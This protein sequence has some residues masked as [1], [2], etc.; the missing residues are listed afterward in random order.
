MSQSQ[1]AKLDAAAKRLE[2]MLAQGQDDKFKAYIQK[3]LKE[4]KVEL[5]RQLLLRMKHPTAK[6]FLDAIN[7]KYPPPQK[8]QVSRNY[9]ML[10]A[11]AV[12][13]IVLV[14]LGALLVPRLLGDNLSQEITCG[15]GDYGVSVRYPEDMFAQCDAFEDVEQPGIELSNNADGLN[16]EQ[17]YDGEIP[18]A[19]SWLAYV[20]WDLRSNYPEAPTLAQ[21]V[22]QGDYALEDTYERIEQ[23]SIGGFDAALVQ[24]VDGFI[25]L[26]DRGEIVSYLDFYGTDEDFEVLLPVF[27]QMALSV[28]AI[29]PTNEQNLTSDVEPNSEVSANINVSLQVRCTVGIGRV[30]DFSFLIPENWASTCVPTDLDTTSVMAVF[31]EN[32]D[33]L[34][35]VFTSQTPSGR[36]VGSIAVENF[37]ENE[38]PCDAWLETLFAGDEAAFTLIGEQNPSECYSATLALRVGAMERI[39]EGIQA[40]LEGRDQP[41]ATIS[42]LYSIVMRV[43]LVDRYIAVIQL[44]PP[45][46]PTANLQEL[47][48]LIPLLDAISESIQITVADASDINPVQETATAEMQ[49]TVSVI[50]TE[51]ALVEAYIIATATAQ[52]QLIT[53]FDY[54]QYTGPIPEGQDFL[55]IPSRR[56][57]DGAFILGNPDARVTV[58]AFMDF[59]CSHCRDYQTTIKDFLSEFVVTGQA[60]Y[61]FRM[62]AISQHSQDLF[63]VAECAGISSTHLFWPAHD[64][65][66]AQAI[67][68]QININTYVLDSANALGLNYDELLDCTTSA[69]QYVVDAQVA[70]ELGVTGIPTLGWRLDGGYLRLDGLSQQPTL[71]E[72]RSLIANYE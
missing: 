62:L 42:P 67:L 34:D 58:V 33:A 41:T 68:G 13:A 64:Y 20:A 23:L 54:S 49:G 57:K 4:D 44:A 8:R 9:A 29:T 72:L 59:L 40:E 46:G 18:P 36:V 35:Q 55:G 37:E 43:M 26:I 38:L 48:D 30:R 69:D 17:G 2:T 28:E 63:A 12:A 15:Q 25:L 22:T 45:G 32:Q 61:E 5:A 24:Y 52:A 71:D 3:L 21:S 16:W 31:A 19:G 10:G 60:Q 11:I 56:G 47:E 14:I 53:A 1:A 66:F 7:A 6:R 39:F 50:Q 51:N 70:N 65:L 27:E